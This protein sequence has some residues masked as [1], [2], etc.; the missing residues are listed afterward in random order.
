MLCVCV[1]P[2]EGACAI[3]GLSVRV[4]ELSYRVELGL[5]RI[6]V[7]F[8]GEGV[9]CFVLDHSEVLARPKLMRERRGGREY[10][11]LFT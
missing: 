5:T 8:E 1:C 3:Q 7:L 2:G 4:L 10:I 6:C 9:R 11:Y